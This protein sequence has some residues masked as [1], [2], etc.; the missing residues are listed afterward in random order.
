MMLYAY[1]FVHLVGNSETWARRI[2]VDDGRLRERAAWALSGLRS[3]PEDGGDS[4]HVGPNRPLGKGFSVLI[5]WDAPGLFMGLKG[6]LSVQP[7]DND[8]TQL[9]L[10]ASYSP[11]GEGDAGDNHR[12]VETAVKRFLDSIQTSLN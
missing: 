4:F 3:L 12:A 8:H 11:D 6:D 2:G 10:R 1:Y 9:T 5:T 7:I